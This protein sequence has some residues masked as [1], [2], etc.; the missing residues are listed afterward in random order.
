MMSN[1]D[2]MKYLN[3]NCIVVLLVVYFGHKFL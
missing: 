1:V 3:P 2:V